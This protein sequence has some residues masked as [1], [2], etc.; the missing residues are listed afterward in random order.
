MARFITL[1]LSYL[2]T[3]LLT[4]F[5]ERFFSEKF[6]NFALTNSLPKN[7]TGESVAVFLLL[8]GTLPFI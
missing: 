5:F 2:I 1:F 8:P 6:K 7:L 3:Y 4:Y